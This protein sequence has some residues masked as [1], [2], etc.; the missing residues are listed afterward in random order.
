MNRHLELIR[1]KA[2][3]LS[4]LVV[5]AV[6][7]GLLTLGI[8]DLLALRAGAPSTATTESASPQPLQPVDDPVAATPDR[9][10]LA[11]EIVARHLFGRASAG[12]SASAS[13][14][15][16]TRLALKLR[17]V[18]AMGDGQGVA[19]IAGTGRGEEVYATGDEISGGV[20]LQEVHPDHVILSRNGRLERL[21]LP[22]GPS[23]F[24]LKE[25]APSLS[26]QPAS[27]AHALRRLR[28][29]AVRNPSRLGQLIRISPAR[30][31]GRLIGYRIEPRGNQPLFE[32]L[33]FHPGDVV[34][35][36]NGTRLDDPRHNLKV[37]RELM[38]AKQFQVTLLRDGQELQITQS[39]E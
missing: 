34:V 13:K 10:D 33:G 9:H 28:Q 2:G 6:G 21:D 39:L 35:A 38:Q 3:L 26:R 12:P 25:A 1:G 18:V 8:R 29:E 14:A 20:L 31:D 27:P 37:M 11:R 22:R 24:S 32:Q 36:V 15:P 4:V 7:L 5:L 16:P 30:K 23:A 19:L 17:G